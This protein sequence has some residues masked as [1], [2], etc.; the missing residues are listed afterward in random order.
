[1]FSPDVKYSQREE[2]M[3]MQCHSIMLPYKTGDELLKKH[4]AKSVMDD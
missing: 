2:I 4:S 3:Q 1:M